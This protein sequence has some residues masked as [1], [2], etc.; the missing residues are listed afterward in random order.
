[1]ES[2]TAADIKSKM[3]KHFGFSTFKSS[4]QEEAVMNIYDGHK[5]VIVSLPTQ[6]GKSLTFHIQSKHKSLKE[7]ETVNS[8]SDFQ[9]F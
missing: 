7:F 9:V 8:H 6:G 4:H 2:L 3:L 1:M 5:N